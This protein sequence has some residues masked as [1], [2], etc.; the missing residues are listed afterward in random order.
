VLRG[1]VTLRT[2]KRLDWNAVQM[3]FP[4]AAEADALVNP[5][6]HNGWSPDGG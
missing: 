5:P 1:N 6:Y 4:N 3:R 2:G